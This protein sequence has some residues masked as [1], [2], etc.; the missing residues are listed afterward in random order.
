MLQSGH[1]NLVNSG[2]SWYWQQNGA[3]NGLFD[4]AR[5]CAENFLW[6]T[7]L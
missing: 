2:G 7:W 3:K 5:D 4:D 1:G 6:T